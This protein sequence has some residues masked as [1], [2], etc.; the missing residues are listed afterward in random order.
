MSTI[1]R[2]KQFFT[3]FQFR[4]VSFKIFL[5]SLWILPVYVVFLIIYVA[6]VLSHSTT[7]N[8]ENF[9]SPLTLPLTILGYIIFVITSIAVIG[10]LFAPLLSEDEMLL[11]FKKD[12]LLVTMGVLVSLCLLCSLNPEAIGAIPFLAYL[13]PILFIILFRGKLKKAGFNSLEINQQLG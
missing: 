9:T 13:S 4:K 8:L 10:V 3:S 11:K 2:L 12:S 7:K 6:F 5:H 1:S